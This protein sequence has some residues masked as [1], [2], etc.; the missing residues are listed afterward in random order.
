M[1]ASV[2]YLAAELVSTLRR[3]QPE[4]NI[5]ETDLVC[6]SLA[7]LCHDLGHG[8]F[9]HMWETFMAQ[10]RPE[11]DWKVRT[12]MTGSVVLSAPQPRI[13]AR[14]HGPFGMGSTSDLTC[15]DMESAGCFSDVF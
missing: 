12:E 2:A 14:V 7:G 13:P 11:R 9:S 3:N 15:I 5:T 6:V 8:P 4:L 10:V 1:F